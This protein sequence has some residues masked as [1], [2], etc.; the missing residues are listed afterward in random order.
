[1]TALRGQIEPCTPGEPPTEMNRTERP[2]AVE[3]EPAPAEA[4]PLAADIVAKYA[5]EG[6]DVAGLTAADAGILQTLEGLPYKDNEERLKELR[7][8]VGY[9]AE[10]RR[11]AQNKET[12]AVEPEEAAAAKEAAETTGTI[13]EAEAEKMIPAA[14]KRDVFDPEQE[15]RILLKTRRAVEDRI[16]G[17][18]EAEQADARELLRLAFRD[19]LE[20]FKEQLVEQRRGMSAILGSVR[21]I[22]LSGIETEAGPPLGEMIELADQ[23]TDPG[24]PAEALAAHKKLDQMRHRLSWSN[25]KRAEWW[26]HG[27]PLEEIM[28]PKKTEIDQGVLQAAVKEGCD[29]ARLTPEQRRVFERLAEK[30]IDRREAITAAKEH[31]PTPEALYR[32][33]FGREPLGKVTVLEGPITLYFRCE[34]LEDYA[35]IF[36]QNFSDG[37]V[38]VSDE[39]RARATKTGGVSISATRA[40]APNLERDPDLARP[41]GTPD[42][43]KAEK[44]RQLL[45]RLKGAVIA[46]NN[47][48]P[49]KLLDR[50]RIYRHEE[51]HALKKIVGEM[52]M[53]RQTRT[54]AESLRRTEEAEAAYENL[55]ERI[56]DTVMAADKIRD[57]GGE[58]EKDLQELREQIGQKEKD[59]TAAEAAMDSKVGAYAGA[60]IESAAKDEILAYYLEGRLG[61]AVEIYDLEVVGPAPDDPDEPLNAE[62]KDPYLKEAKTEGGIYDY[63]ANP[64]AVDWIANGLVREAAAQEIVEKIYAPDENGKPVDRDEVD[65]QAIREEVALK[66]EQRRQTLRPLVR[67]AIKE[68]QKGYHQTLDDAKRAIDILES[69]GMGK[70]EIIDVLTLEPLKSWPRLASRLIDSRGKTAVAAGSGSAEKA[71]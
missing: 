41:D 19:R 20:Q 56:L 9:V 13:D 55:A 44:R 43:V 29:A 37:E 51:Q 15:L 16:S 12:S 11:A 67:A 48:V 28:S 68:H 24:S 53:D 3:P 66:D 52:D 7:E 27:R 58:P 30:V 57:K 6:I 10:N 35:L 38:S 31:A 40:H 47:T 18:P 17:K 32:F 4:E 65:K 63:H 1:M 25:I 70:P 36:S 33:C 69:A 60:W 14:P 46:E 62:L 42:P 21:E 26:K 54:A 8:L 2:P 5:A 64:A 49:R 45:L 71:A 39:D 50:W 61:E 59:Q 23:A 34:N 22:V